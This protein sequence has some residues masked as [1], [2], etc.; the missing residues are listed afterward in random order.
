MFK[1]S[2]SRLMRSAVY[3]AAALASIAPAAAQSGGTLSVYGFTRT[4]MPTP[5]TGVKAVG[6][7]RDFIP[8]VLPD[9]SVQL[10]RNDSPFYSGPADLHAKAV[11]VSGK[12]IFA[13]RE[14]GTVACWDRL[15]T[16]PIFTDLVDVRKISTNTQSSGALALTGAGTVA[17]YSYALTAPGFDYVAGLSGVKDIACGDS[18]YGVVQQDGTVY[19]W[20]GNEYQELKVPSSAT[21]VKTLAVGWHH[22]LALKENGTVVAWGDD[23]AGQCDVP[24]GLTNVVAVSAAANYS[25]ALQSNGHVVVWGDPVAT[26]FEEFPA[27]IDGVSEITAVHNGL[28]VLRTPPPAPFPGSF[29]TN[30]TNLVGGAKATLSGTITLASPA[31]AAT[32]VSISSSDP[33]ITVPET[34]TIGKGKTSGNFKFTTSVV[35]ADKTVTLSAKMAGTESKKVDIAL[36][37]LALEDVSF[38]L[39]TIQGGRIGSGTVKVPFAV[40]MDTPITVT[41]ASSFM[42]VDP[43]YIP[44]GKSSVTFSYWGDRVFTTESADVT[45]ALG[46]SELTRS[47]TL[48]PAPKVQS[49]KLSDTYANRMVSGTI[50]LDSRAPAD[51]MYL[52]LEEV[53]PGPNLQYPTGQVWIYVPAGKSSVP[54]NVN[55]LDAPTEMPLTIRVNGGDYWDMP[56]FAVEKTINVKPLTIAALTVNTKTVTTG[57]VA[58]LTITMNQPPQV[59][60]IWLNL[61]VAGA[62]VESIDNPIVQVGQLSTTIAIRFYKVSKTE[63]TTITVIGP[64]WKS[65]SITLTVKP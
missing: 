52:T 1:P 62:G 54:F 58:Y 39:S 36:R 28:F 43:F 50:Y 23:S 34:I 48:T 40:S 59:Q 37:P 55:L 6:A 29:V 53:L 20:G 47:I 21:N 38:S 60:P 4:D 65:Q 24:V 8:V 3:A 2:F 27:S 41:T 42:H 63:K 46:N 19:C 15:R 49:I 35:D 33:A 30:V 45:F 44:A 31:T 10:Y 7:G 5:L 32:T 17:A 13:I 61:Q 56:E 9:G 22:A 11:A 25:V 12:H 16:Q 18:F 51:G 14:D 26:V 64:D 57:D